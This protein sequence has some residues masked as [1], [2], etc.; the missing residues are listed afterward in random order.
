MK[1]FAS[2]NSNYLYINPRVQKY[3][4]LLKITGKGRNTGHFYK[5]LQK[6]FL[7]FP[8]ESGD[9]FIQY[10]DD[11][12]KM[13]RMATQFDMLV[14]MLN[15][16]YGESWDFHYKPL[17]NQ[18]L[19]F[20]VDIII[21]YP[22]IQIS[23]GTIT[24]NIRDLFVH[25]QISF[26]DNLELICKPPGGFRTTYSYVEWFQGYD[27]SH[28]RTKD[29]A[30]NK[31]DTFFQG[32]FFC[33]GANTDLENILNNVFLSHEYVFNTDVFEGFLY[34]IDDA[35][36]WESLEGGPYIRISTL[37]SLI[38]SRNI[39]HTSKK[40]N[41]TYFNRN[42][43]NFISEFSLSHY[44]IFLKAKYQENKIAIDN[45]EELSWALKEF[46]S[47]G[48]AEGTLDLI[49]S[50]MLVANNNKNKVYDFEYY[51]KY[52][53]KTIPI[54]VEDFYEQLKENNTKENIESAPYF[55]FR[56]TEKYIHVDPMPADLE[57]NTNNYFLHPSFLKLF[58]KKINIKIHQNESK[59]S[60]IRANS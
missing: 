38:P 20:T 18:E 14:T 7:K 10:Y 16:H 45:N 49:Y 6:G 9:I 2:N 8:A 23:N 40:V 11:R 12:E 60:I 25:T 56:N 5:M 32:S 26:N 48:L 33:L 19:S 44:S 46:I 43:D 54:P 36:E 30:R 22:D 3:A 51:I 55:Q 29:A 35:V 27:H 58:I 15:T 47:E 50:D 28:L 24:H 4:D 39:V 53:R 52:Y 13:V 42:I 34:A 31:P 21:H 57:N 59:K 37:S 1:N 17:K 41:L